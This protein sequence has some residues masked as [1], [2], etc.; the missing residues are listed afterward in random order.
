[1]SKPILFFSI[2]YRIPWRS[3]PHIKLCRPW[4]LG[5]TNF[6]HWVTRAPWSCPCCWNQCDD[7]TLLWTGFKGLP[8]LLL[9][10]YWRPRAADTKD[11][12][13]TGG[14]DHTKSDSIINDILQ[15]NAIAYAIIETRTISWSWGW[16]FC[17][18]CQHKGKLCRSLGEGPRNRWLRQLWV[19]CRWQSFPTHYSWKSLWG[20]NDHPQHSFGQ[21]SDEGR[22]SGSS[23][24]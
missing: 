11:Q 5:C 20:V 6:Y 24:C 7:Q 4:T 1:M 3:R 15:P 2:D 18:S 21:W 10:G 13:P 17:Y 9:H 22:C 14:A 23:R 8:Q 19:V 16:S 12:R